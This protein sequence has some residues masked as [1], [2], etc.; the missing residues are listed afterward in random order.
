MQDGF[1]KRDSEIRLLR[2]NVVIHTG[3]ID[4][5]KRFKNDVSEVKAGFE[6]GLTI[7][8]FSDM[9]AGDMVEAF[10]T[11]RVAVEAMA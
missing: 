2:D 9:K 10:A 3:K 8:N 7:R 1:I 4:T 5:L 6:C 11:E